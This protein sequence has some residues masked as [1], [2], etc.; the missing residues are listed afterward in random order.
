M[1]TTKKEDYLV[2][3]SEA[4]EMQAERI[5]CVSGGGSEHSGE[6]DIPLP[7]MI[8]DGFNSIF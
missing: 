7:T 4:F 1:K 2:P 6:G 5:I 3:E 8:P